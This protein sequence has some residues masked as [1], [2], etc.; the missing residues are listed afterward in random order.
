MVRFPWRPVCRALVLVGA[1]CRPLAALDFVVTRY[2]DPFPDGCAPTDCSLRE[3][4]IAANDSA[5]ADRIV[6]S[7]GTYSLTRF[8]PDDVGALGDL[9]L[10]DATEIVGPAATMT[11][12]DATP[13]GPASPDPVL[14]VFVGATLRGV[15]ILGGANGGVRVSGGD[16]T[17]EACEVMNNAF[18]GNS[19][20]ILATG[21][22]TIVIRDSAIINNGS[23]L[24]AVGSSVTMENVTLNSNGQNQIIVQDGSDLVC[25][26]CTVVDPVGGSPEIRVGATSNAAFANSIVSGICSSFS[27]GT[28][29]SLAGNVESPGHSC[30]FTLAGDRDDVADPGLTALGDHGGGTRTFNL[31]TGN[32]GSDLVEASECSVHDQRGVARSFHFQVPCDSGAVERVTNRVTTPIFEDGFE[33]GDGEAWSSLVGS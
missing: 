8:G 22:G 30:G 29:S 16:L 1:V 11:R 33:Q 4:T 15:T 6:L 32:P 21:G 17:M 2:N 25:T 7:A 12:I 23:G 24:E 5:G 14:T 3:A 20:G 19:A 31:V 9:D 26:H 27:G 28:Y 13:L 18:Q 10:L